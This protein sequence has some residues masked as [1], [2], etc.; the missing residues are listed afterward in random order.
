MIAKDH[1]LQLITNRNWEALTQHLSHLS[2]MDFRKAERTIRESILPTLPSDLFW[3]AM[4]H[5]IKYKKQAFLTGMLA[6]DKILTRDS[7]TLQ[8]PDAR[9]FASFIAK[10]HPEAMAKLVNMALPLLRTEQ[11]IEDLFSAFDIHDGRL[12]VASLIK[13]PSPL[14][15]FALF[16]TLKMMPDNQDLVRKC[17]IHIMKSG[18]DQAFNMASILRA[19]FGIEGMKSQMSLSIDTYELNYLDRNYDTFLHIL[20]GRRPKI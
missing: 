10:E 5:L 8:H 17:C 4:L 7:S 19:Y 11:Q 12:R 16:K 3:C 6:I 15:Y 18:S 14:T 13:A 20:N 1:I 2:N 9:S